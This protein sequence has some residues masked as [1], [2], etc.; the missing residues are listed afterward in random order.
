MKPFFVTN[1]LLD[2]YGEYFGPD[3]LVSVKGNLEDQS[4]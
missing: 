3:L 1:E 2:Y 4:H